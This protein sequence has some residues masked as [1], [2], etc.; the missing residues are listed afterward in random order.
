MKEVG[1]IFTFNPSKSGDLLL[2]LGTPGGITLLRGISSL[3]IEFSPVEHV[4]RYF[5][6]VEATAD[7]VGIHSRIECEIELLSGEPAHEYLL[8]M[9]KS[10]SAGDAVEVELY[11][12]DISA[13]SSPYPCRRRQYSFIPRTLCAGSMGAGLPAFTLA[14][15]FK[16]R[17][18]AEC[19]AAALSPDGQTMNFYGAPDS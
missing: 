7:L 13:G 18:L 6:E 15:E 1:D 4:R 16:A 9:I 5:D 12:V 11:I 2:Y 3:K 8:G 19:G 14:C 17:S 10:G